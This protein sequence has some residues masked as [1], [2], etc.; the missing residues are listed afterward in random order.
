MLKKYLSAVIAVFLIATGAM[1]ISLA[2]NEVE[3][4]S[5]MSWEDLLGVLASLE[6]RN[7]H[8]WDYV[9][10]SQPL[11]AKYTVLGSYEVSCEEYDAGANAWQKY[12]I[13]YPQELP[14]S[15]ET[16]PLVIM[17]NGTGV[18]A[19]QYSE[20]FR[21]LA[22]WGFIVAGNEDENS[23]TG[24]SSAAT[25]D[26]L[27]ALN[28]NPD[29]VFFGKI[30][31]DHIGIAGHSQGGVGAINAVTAQENGSYYSAM[32]T[33]SCT[34]PYHAENLGADWTYDTAK[35]RIPYMLVGGTGFL[36]AGNADTA[37]QE[38][39]G[40]AQGICSLWSMRQNYDAIPSGVAKVMA[41]RVGM[42]HGDMLR[43]ADGYMTAWFMWQLQGDEEAALA[44]IGENP[45]IAV[46][47]LYQDQQ[48]SLSE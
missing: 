42:D 6:D 26:Y 27:L 29:S 46:N 33:A 20:V 23:R 30:D 41:R 48:I 12:M 19:S 16:W 3:E 8:Y 10:T 25:L 1:G 31:I 4:Q 18:K 39:D 21:H 11:E 7:T 43:N 45:E 13:W 32:W 15:N 36:D 14:S 5:E 44:F 34:S 2:E 47:P 17:A 37:D 40:I 22:S 24:E 38:G 35:I 9:E 28:N